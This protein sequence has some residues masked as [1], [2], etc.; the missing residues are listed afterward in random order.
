[1]DFKFISSVNDAIQ[2]FKP[3][4]YLCLLYD[5]IFTFKRVLKRKQKNICICKSF[6]STLP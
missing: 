1:M 6:S 3:G 4:I 2:I 5:Y